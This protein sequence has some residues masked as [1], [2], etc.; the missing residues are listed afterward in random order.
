M[1]IFN[2][3]DSAVQDWLASCEAR[4]QALVVKVANEKNEDEVDSNFGGDSSDE[5]DAEDAEGNNDQRRSVTTLPAQ[6]VGPP[7]EESG[8]TAAGVKKLDFSKITTPAGGDSCVEKGVITEGCVELEKEN[9]EL[10]PQSMGSSLSDPVVAS[11]ARSRVTYCPMSQAKPSP[12]NRHHSTVLVDSASASPRE[13]RREKITVVDEPVTPVVT[14]DREGRFIN[15]VT[16]APGKA[17]DKL[18]EKRSPLVSTTGSPSMRSPEKSAV[19]TAVTGSEALSGKS[20]AEEGIFRFAVNL[21]DTC[22]V[23]DT[24]LPPS[25]GTPTNCLI[26]TP[27]ML[28]EDLV[29]EKSDPTLAMSASNVQR[30]GPLVGDEARNGWGDRE[31]LRHASDGVVS[32]VDDQ[33]R[34]GA[35]D[36]VRNRCQLDAS[37]RDPN[38][39]PTL[40]YSRDAIN[41]EDVGIASPTHSTRAGKAKDRMTPDEKSDNEEVR[42]DSRR[43]EELPDPGRKQESP[44]GLACAA[45][46]FDDNGG[47]DGCAT[48]CEYS[49]GDGSDHDSLP[50]FFVADGNMHEALGKSKVVNRSRS[51]GVPSEGVERGEAMGAS[52]GGLIAVGFE[53]EENWDED[54]G[55]ETCDEGSIEQDINAG[56]TSRRPTEATVAGNAALG[57]DPPGALGNEDR[58]IDPPLENCGENVDASKGPK[59]PPFCHQA[60]KQKISELDSRETTSSMV[61]KIPATE[62]DGREM[63]IPGCA[64]QGVASSHTPV[65]GETTGSILTCPMRLASETEISDPRDQVLER[66]KHPGP[67]DLRELRVEEADQ[68]QVGRSW[69]KLPRSPMQQTPEVKPQK[70][71]SKDEVKLRNV[72]LHIGDTLDEVRNTPDSRQAIEKAGTDDCGTSNDAT[73][74]SATQ[75]HSEKDGIAGTDDQDDHIS[76][77]EMADQS[78]GTQEVPETELAGFQSALG[79]DSQCG[80]SVE[81]PEPT[82]FALVKDSSLPESEIPETPQVQDSVSLSAPE[83][84]SSGD[85]DKSTSH[86]TPR[87]ASCEAPEVLSGRSSVTLSGE[88]A[89]IRAQSE[90][91]STHEGFEGSPGARGKDSSSRVGGGLRKSVELIL[92][93]SDV[94]IHAESPEKKCKSTTP[95]VERSSVGDSTGGDED[96]SSYSERGCDASRRDSE[97]VGHDLAAAQDAWQAEGN[98][99]AGDDYYE[100]AAFSQNTSDERERTGRPRSIEDGSSTQCRQIREVSNPYAPDAC[101]ELKNDDDPLS[102]ATEGPRPDGGGASRENPATDGKTFS[103]RRLRHPLSRPSSAT[104]SFGA[105]SRANTLVGPAVLGSANASARIRERDRHRTSNKI[106]RAGKRGLSGKQESVVMTGSWLSYDMGPDTLVR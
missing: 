90:G 7:N 64:S 43:D 19:E 45:D 72:P 12:E 51:Q 27:P 20:G 13:N 105:P 97:E 58:D 80:V 52:D 59:E 41:D 9:V 91:K 5:S 93:A 15:G 106:L 49:P 2:V 26:R 39:T 100:Y 62:H 66:T 17:I 46:A 78:F 53:H 99:G 50:L 38:S 33:D 94:S 65:T 77:T 104:M 68:Q 47:G 60:G 98:N 89:D 70:N 63:E 76:E 83:R 102:N 103:S 75:E 34:E 57:N 23:I 22:D 10:S 37:I 56:S 67:P 61:R 92:S 16:S 54:D 8:E 44:V 21:P 86:V 28:R 35:G 14:I 36:V 24:P 25:P 55:E 88:T 6:K 42:H 96:H 95:P 4:Y 48:E 40:S 1:C 81:W 18:E 3:Q 79:D 30:A 11:F 101:L 85:T 74:C 32:F 29:W 69:T 87:A 82:P 84:D 71:P 73:V 31:R